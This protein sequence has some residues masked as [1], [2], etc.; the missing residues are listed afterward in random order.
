MR[1][2][3]LIPAIF[4]LRVAAVLGAIYLRISGQ[5]TRKETRQLLAEIAPLGSLSQRGEILGPR[6]LLP[7]LL[8]TPSRSAST[9]HDF[10]K[11]QSEDLRERT[12][13]GPEVA[14][15]TPLKAEAGAHRKNKS[16]PVFGASVGLLVSKVSPRAAR[17]TCVPEA[18]APR[19][20]RRDK[21][22]RPILRPLPI[23]TAKTQGPRKASRLCWSA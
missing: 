4:V 9:T 3:R 17:R 23:Q 19:Y 14:S 2:L 16:Q 8:D 20:H 10:L 5:G 7:G 22:P 21:T 6:D 15:E 1:H 13:T 11:R 18:S 12:A